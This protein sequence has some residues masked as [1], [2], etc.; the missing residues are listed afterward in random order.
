[1]TSPFSTTYT[2]ESEQSRSSQRLYP[3]L[4]C[5]W[6]HRL[7][8]EYQVRLQGL[9]PSFLSMKVL[10]TWDFP[11]M[12][13]F[14]T[15]LTNMTFPTTFTLSSGLWCTSSS[16][17]WSNS[18]SAPSQRNLPSKTSHLWSV[19]VL[20]DQFRTPKSSWKNSSLRSCRMNSILYPLRCDTGISRDLVPAIYDMEY[21]HGRDELSEYQ[22]SGLLVLFNE[23]KR[24]TLQVHVHRSEKFPTSQWDCT[25]WGSSSLSG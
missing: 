17:L 4:G 21:C 13:T 1:M 22:Y 18:T 23:W 11:S 8:S 5:I 9:Q 24:T 15:S 7:S 19:L 20:A 3:T 10:M 16:F 12:L 25:L 2:P 14:N 6:L